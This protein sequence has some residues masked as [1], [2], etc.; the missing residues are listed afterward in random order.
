ME[1]LPKKRSTDD[2]ATFTDASLVELGLNDEEVSI[3]HDYLRRM[4]YGPASA[5]A[6]LCKGPA[7]EY[8]DKCP[9]AQIGKLPE[10][11][12]DCPIERALVEGWVKELVA[13]LDIN[14]GDAIDQA[15]IRHLINLR[16]LDK[17]AMETMANS[18]IMVKEF[19]A[20]SI[21]GEPIYEN[22]VHPLLM[23]LEKNRKMEDRILS[24]LIA[25]RE[26]KSK[27]R[28]RNIPI[29]KDQAATILERIESLQREQSRTVEATIKNAE[30]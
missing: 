18:P 22:R 30:E 11:K 8:I 16:L 7:C 13:E 10:F 5:G 27:D 4:R 21:D 20:M 26:S 29:G 14:T 19:R 23:A 28:A 3:V 9:L 2:L 1:N 24:A 15:Q 12:S 17:R 6:L 25:T